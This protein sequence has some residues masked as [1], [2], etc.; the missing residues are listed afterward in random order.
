MTLSQAVA[1]QLINRH[2]VPEEKIHVLFH[3]DLE[4]GAWHAPTYRRKKPLRLLFFGRLLPYKGLDLFVDALEI[5]RRKGVQFT[6]SV[7]GSGDVGNQ[8][9]RLS[10]LGVKVDNRW[11]PSREITDVFAQHDLVIC[12]H[13][14]ASQ[15][16]VVATAHGAGIPVVVTPVG[17]LLDQ[18][19]PEV[20]GIIAEA[21]TSE[22]VADAV[23]RVADDKDLLLRLQRGVLADREKRSLKKLL[24]ALLDVA[25][26]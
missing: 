15:S 19:R 17:G 24:E 13:R 10:S 2:V 12:S 9:Q 18:I 16:G 26:A 21:A 25:L 22:A 20:N 4:H 8:T 23:R 1:E 6:A 11:I 7:V 14:E 5:L 3:P